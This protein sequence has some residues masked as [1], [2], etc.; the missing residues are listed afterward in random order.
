MKKKIN[1]ITLIIRGYT[2]A[3]TLMIAE[4]AN[5]YGCFNLEITTN[6]DGWEEMIRAVISKNYE[7][8]I[9]GAGT[10]LDLELL[11]KAVAAGSEFVLAPIPMSKSM[12]DYCKDHDVISVPAAF[13]PGEIYEMKRNGADIIKL[14]PAIDLPPRYLKDIM[15][16]LGELP[17]MVVGGINKNNAK[18]YFAMGAQYA[19]IGSGICNKEELREGNRNSLIENLRELAE[20]AKE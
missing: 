18:D 12:L 15:A 1:K 6:T 10:V 8:L 4:E 16:P 2:L 13:S 5:N 11:E 17:I 19:G 14:F 20:L 3:E 9:V 7:N